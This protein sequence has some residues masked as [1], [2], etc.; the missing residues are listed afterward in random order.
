MGPA[1]SSVQRNGNYLT[2]YGV[3]LFSP[4]EEEHSASDGFAT[5]QSTLT[6]NGVPIAPIYSGAG[7]GLFPVPPEDAAY[8]LTTTGTRQVP[9]ATLVTQVSATYAFRSQAPPSSAP[10]DLPLM[11]VRA[12]GLVDD[13]DIAPAGELYLLALHVER[14]PL[15]P[16]ASVTDLTLEVSY[17]DGKSWQSAPLV[18]FADRGLA[19]LAHPS[20]AAFVSLR[21]SARDADGNAVTQTTTRAYAL[22]PRPLP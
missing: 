12:A 5:G 1:A 6:R 19:I 18:R 17:D 22:Q 16:P 3:P 15:A 13:N 4:S 10:V 14:P 11:A 9:Y 7:Q 20:D 2:L 8:V 21:M